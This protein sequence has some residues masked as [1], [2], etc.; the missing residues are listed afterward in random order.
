MA[1]KKVTKV[2]RPEAKK[3]L[4]RSSTPRAEPTKDHFKEQHDIVIDLPMGVLR[5]GGKPVKAFKVSAADKNEPFT[6]RQIRRSGSVS[7]NF[8]SIEVPIDSANE[9][10]RIRCQIEDPHPSNGRSGPKG[11]GKLT[12]T[13]K[14]IT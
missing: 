1:K 4:K 11:S 5:Y 12:I 6:K 7:L 8:D 3:K 2:S 10:C 14:P 13:I 9:E